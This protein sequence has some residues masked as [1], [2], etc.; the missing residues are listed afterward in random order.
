MKRI[1]LFIQAYNS[2][3]YL[4]VEPLLC[5]CIIGCFIRGKGLWFNWNAIFFVDS[6]NSF[7]VIM[8][9]DYIPNSWYIYNT[10]SGYQRNCLAIMFSHLM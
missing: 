5:M 4:Y 2:L 9:D 10:T 8:G 3:I 7:D 1:A 6:W